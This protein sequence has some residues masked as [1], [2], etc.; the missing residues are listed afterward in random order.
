MGTTG[1]GIAA[2][3]SGFAGLEKDDGGGE[4]LPDLL[5]DSGEALQRLAFADV[6]DQRGAID[7]G[8]LAD[9]IGEARQQFERQIVD[10]VVAEVFKGLESRGFAGAG[11]SGE[12]DELAGAGWSG[13]GFRFS[14]WFG[15]CLPGCLWLR[16]VWNRFCGP[17]LMLALG[18]LGT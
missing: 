9:E 5:K 15:F 8:G 3:Q 17:W 11:E 4:R 7:L 12:D 10:G 1:F 13:L 14:G 16:L 2:E 6:D 18:M